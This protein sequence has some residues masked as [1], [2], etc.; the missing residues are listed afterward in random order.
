M[1][2]RNKEAQ[3]E[4][5]SKKNMFLFL[6]HLQATMETFEKLVDGGDYQKKLGE[7]NE[8]Y[9]RLLKLVDPKSVKKAY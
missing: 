8:E 6:G 2:A 4:F 5:Q 3:A 9:G 1:L 7:L